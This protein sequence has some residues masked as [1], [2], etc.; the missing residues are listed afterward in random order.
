MALARYDIAWKHLS[1]RH[2]EIDDWLVR[3]LDEY[4]KNRTE[5]FAYA[6]IGTFGSGKTQ[7]LYYIHKCVKEKEMLPLYFIAEDLF[8]EVLKSRE[9]FAQDRIFTP[10]DLYNLI[11]EKINQLKKALSI[12]DDLR[13]KEIVDPRGKLEKDA[14]EVLEM[15]VRDFSNTNFENLKVVLLVDEL[16]GQYGILQDK[17]QTRDR[18]PLREWLESKSYL[19]FLA[20][21]PAG[22]YELGGADRDRVKRIVLPPADIDY[23]REK[24]IKEIGLSNASWWLSRGK[25]RQLFKACE[26]LREKSIPLEASEVFRIIRD[27]LDSIG[28][29]PT[30][31][32]AA[33]TSAVD[34]SKI[35]FLINLH[36][37]ETESARR[38]VIDT[39]RL[40]TG[41]LASKLADAFRL[42]KDNAILI[43]EYFKRTVKALSNEK[44]I[45]YIQDKD[46]PELFCLVF[47]HLLE[48][49]HGSPEL[50][51]TLGEILSLYETVKREEAALYG[52][53]GR[54][55]E[56]KETT[57]QLPLTIGEIRK[58]FPFPTMNPIVK[59]HIPAE[60]KKKWEGKGLPIW[61]WTEGDITV[62]FFVSER[63]FVN[64]HEKDEFLSLALPDGK[65]VLC[66]FSTGEIL[67]EK[68]T[69]VTWLEKNEK[70]RL[71]ELPPL[72]SDFLLSAT[73]EIQGGIP[74]DLDLC[75]KNFKQNKEDILLSRKSE[76]YS[77]AISEITRSFLPS[78]RTYCKELLPDAVDVWGKTKI[79]D[80][81]PVIIGIA[82]A[83]ADLTRDEK[84]LLSDLMMLFKGGREGKGI[85]DLRPLLPH[86]GLPTLADDLLPRYGV[87]K[88]LKDSEPISR[89]K[90]YWR[91]NEKE[92]LVEL[93][94]ILPLDHFLKLHTEEDMSRLL[95]ALWRT[96]RAEFDIEGLE[97]IVQT[98]EKDIL[99]MLEE[100]HELERKGISDF[101]LSG[102]NF[103]SSESL[104]KA[105]G[106]FE[107]LRDIAKSALID[108]G[109][110]SS[111]AR[112]I[113]NAFMS[114]LNVESDVRSIGSL[115]S[116]VKKALDDLTTAGEKL[117]K[118]FWEY[119]RAT[120]F[121]GITEDEVKTLASEK[122]KI[123]GILTLQQLNNKS[124]ENTQYLDDVSA[125]LGRLD[126]K[127][128]ELES[129]FNQILKS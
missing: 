112:C 122:K 46:L 90:A 57:W 50:S 111:L 11:E 22:I 62:L 93:T 30:V 69:L 99:P 7:L 101:G 33:V 31:V 70:F 79:Q 123:S 56:L 128:A 129:I 110:A 77:E 96:V 126:R 43:S 98:F 61:K 86:G 18:S 92:K 87:K 105:K 65:G 91:E 44:G 38:Y 59:N 41:Q 48:Y 53:V 26:L 114:S 83:F 37:I 2:K 124:K 10:G 36:P 125:N 73:G 15:L 32:P 106:G 80:R 14:P 68:K 89:L 52:I 97:T 23:V 42:N 100:C 27:E 63:D 54:S 67:K 16:E 72:L 64:Y 88:E 13:V 104:V 76:I 121:V 34:P 81:G 9:I 40:E 29:A 28:Q 78:P 24:L 55:W 45:T 19:K 8:K 84:Q 119:R 75:L 120:K 12:K 82:L 47:D 49:E 60:M 17:V 21:A 58:A 1:D 3:M 116:S 107:K 51:E 103:E 74:G 25:A 118:N 85:G 6:I 113:V 108:E 66:L 71:V 94:R 109:S 95:E 127:L 5:H 4:A 117:I 20:F 115:A 102:L 39:D 35:P